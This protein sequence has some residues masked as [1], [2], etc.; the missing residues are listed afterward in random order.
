ME[1][2]RGHSDLSSLCSL[3]NL[4]QRE[5][6]YSSVFEQDLRT[7]NIPFYPLAFLISS[8][9]AYLGDSSPLLCAAYASHS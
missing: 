9:S 1:F 6:F 7:R 2:W 8:Y 3:Q 5:L 4:Y